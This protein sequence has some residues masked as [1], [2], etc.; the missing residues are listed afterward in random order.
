MVYPALL[1]LM[2][3]T[4]LPAVDWTDASADLN[5]LVRF[6]ERRY[7]VSA[8]VPSHFSWP[9]I[10]KSV[11]SNNVRTTEKVQ[12]TETCAAFSSTTI[13]QTNFRSALETSPKVSAD[14][15][16]N[17]SQRF[18]DNN[19]PVASTNVGKFPLTLISWKPVQHFSSCVLCA[20]PQTDW[21]RQGKEEANK[22]A[23][24]G[25]GVVTASQYKL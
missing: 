3:T 18:T 6:A 23:W 9:L 20:D 17:N 1:P 7:L 16:L 2:R 5:G 14:P 11:I 12:R 21:R 22:C 24:R 13:F 10:S 19:K 25:Q 15:Q 8:R 4:R